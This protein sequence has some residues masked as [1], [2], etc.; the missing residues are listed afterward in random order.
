[1][2]RQ[3]RD[4]RERFEERVDRS[5][6]PNACHEWLG[7]RSEFGYGCFSNPGH[8]NGWTAAH[9]AAWEFEHGSI[10]EGR[11][12][13]HHCDNPPCVNVKHLFLGNNDANVADMVSKRR[14]RPQGR[15]PIRVGERR[16]R[17]TVAK[18]RPPAAERTHCPIGHPYS[19][20]NTYWH[21]ATAKRAP[22]RHC[23]TCMRAQAH[24]AYL[25][26]KASA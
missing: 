11:H 1:M 26:R 21:P 6:G 4:P 17:I 5:G 12:V 25:R 19:P 20:E 14:H 9:R 22:Y 16:R 10:P 13:L 18:G 24:A 3:A 8:S 2:A 7:A 23:R 15:K